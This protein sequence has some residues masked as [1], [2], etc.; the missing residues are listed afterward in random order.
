MMNQDGGSEDKY[1]MVP[2]QDLLRLSSEE[3][4]AACAGLP[5][6]ALSGPADLLPAA[7]LQQQRP[8]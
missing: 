7:W 6:W 8:A 2:S 3:L 1:E 5:E 4:S